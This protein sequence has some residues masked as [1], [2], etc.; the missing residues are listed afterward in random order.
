MAIPFGVSTVGLGPSYIYPL[1]WTEPLTHMHSTLSLGLVAVGQTFCA[2]Q[3]CKCKVT[4]N[5]LLDNVSII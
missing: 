1:V 5:Q 2:V 4:T 3:Q